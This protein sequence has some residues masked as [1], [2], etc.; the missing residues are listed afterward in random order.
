MWQ[1]RAHRRSANLR[2]RVAVNSLFAVSVVGMQDTK[3]LSGISH[4][5]QG[6]AIAPTALF[7]V[8]Y[9]IRLRARGRC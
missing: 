3:S 8:R 9:A 5:L 4:S 1:R 7:A 6:A 2:R